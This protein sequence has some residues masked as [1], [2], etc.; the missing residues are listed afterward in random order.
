MIL[1]ELAYQTEGYW[2]AA[3]NSSIA[4]LRHIG[5]KAAHSS[6]PPWAP[7]FCDAPSDGIEA[8]QWKKLRVKMAQFEKS[9]PGPPPGNLSGELSGATLSPLIKPTTIMANKPKPRRTMKPW[10]NVIGYPC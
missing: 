1:L 6:S 7:E 2:Q 5:M 4:C 9:P 8:K 3:Q 10:N